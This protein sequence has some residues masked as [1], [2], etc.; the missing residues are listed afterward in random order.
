[1]LALT[2]AL[3]SLPFAYYFDNL[4]VIFVAAFVFHLFADTLLHW[5]LY[6]EQAGKYFNVLVVLDVG[7]ALLLSWLVTRDQFFT[8]PVLVAIA[9]GL[10][11]D[12][13]HQGAELLRPLWQPRRVP[14]LKQWLRFH[15][16][17]QLET[18][19]IAAGLIWQVVLIAG[20][21]ALVGTF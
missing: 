4:L 17:L 12:A 9:G 6:P 21:L 16:N 19:Q 3:I 15:E 14:L 5:N 18:T 2:H 8:L 11:P 7:A 10:A 20:A 13:L 1:M